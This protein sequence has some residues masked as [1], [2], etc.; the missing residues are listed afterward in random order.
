MTLQL[1]RPNR[2]YLFFKCMIIGTGLLFVGCSR[3]MEEQPSYSFQEAPRLHSP[4]ASVPQ[5]GPAYSRRSTQMISQGQ[6]L[7]SINC[8]HCHGKHGT[9]D[10]AVAGYLPDLPANLQAPAIQQQPDAEL[11]GIVTNGQN[12]MPAFDRFL[13]DEDRWILV[14]FLRSLESQDLSSIPVS[15][16][17]NRQGST[18]GKSF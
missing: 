10:G 16:E 2:S 18:P 1:V 4:Q 12:V 11:Y 15:Q 9:G 8:S 5:S 13:S 6:E 17:S 7:F 3:D 14:S